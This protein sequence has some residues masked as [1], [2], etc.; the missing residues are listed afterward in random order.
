MPRPVPLLL[1]PAPS[2]PTPPPPT[3]S[4]PKP[5]RLRPRCWA[6]SKARPWSCADAAPLLRRGSCGLV[7]A[8]LRATGPS[9]PCWR[10]RAYPSGRVPPWALGVRPVSPSCRSLNSDGAPQDL[11]MERRPAAQGVF[12][13]APTCSSSATPP[14]SSSRAAHLASCKRRTGWVGCWTQARSG[15]MRPR[16]SDGPIAASSGRGQCRRRRGRWRMDMG[17]ANG[18]WREAAVKA[19]R[20]LLM[21]RMEVLGSRARRE[22]R[23]RWGRWTRRSG[24]RI[25]SG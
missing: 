16:P 24:P 17:G 2:P 21:R 19:A 15:Q 3:P 14:L 8:A 18:T 25:S 22:I 5:S 23:M 20:L 7:E 1:P 12:A 9:S 11:W 10:V 13:P 6:D 4:P